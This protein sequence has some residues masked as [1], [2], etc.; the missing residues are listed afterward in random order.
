L[1]KSHNR[2]KRTHSDTNTV[3]VYVVPRISDSPPLSK[4]PSCDA[5]Y[6]NSESPCKKCGETPKKDGNAKKAQTI[7]TSRRHQDTLS[8]DFSERSAHLRSTRVLSQQT[9]TLK[10]PR[11]IISLKRTSQPDTVSRTKASQSE[12]IPLKR[13]ITETP[14]NTPSLSVNNSP[15]SPSNSLPK[16]IVHDQYTSMGDWVCPSCISINK[17]STTRCVICESTPHDGFLEND[18]NIVEWSAIIKSSPMSSPKKQNEWQC[19][20]CDFMNSFMEK[21]CT[22]CGVVRKQGRSN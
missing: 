3:E 20:I 15:S 4:C 8:L 11:D 19:Q 14:N 18:A 12:N 13:T 16:L 7:K 17:P 21:Q 5:P 1:I 9:S 2:H 10:K 6:E 22:M